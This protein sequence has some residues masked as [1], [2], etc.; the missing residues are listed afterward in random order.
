MLAHGRARIRREG[1]GDRVRLIRG[2]LP[3]AR[4]PLAGYDAIISNSLLHH[5][6]EPMALW[7]TIKSCARPGAPLFVM[8]LLR[9]AGREQARALVD[10][11][12]AGEPDV[13]RRDFFQSLLAAY[14]PGE[15]EA[16]LRA[17]GLTSLKVAPVSDRHLLVF[18]AAP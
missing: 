15:V 4:L 12:A 1:L 13:L 9:P 11:Y 10:E 18:G 14:R 7:D 17:A 5:L 6:R 3:G 2:Y 16:Q 8:D